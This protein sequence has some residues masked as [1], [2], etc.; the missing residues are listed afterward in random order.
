MADL[1][2]TVDPGFGHLPGHVLGNGQAAEMAPY[3]V[4]TSSVHL[5]FAFHLV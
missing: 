5:V 2:T 1:S 3:H 4:G